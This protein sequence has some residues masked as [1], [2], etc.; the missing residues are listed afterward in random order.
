LP[1]DFNGDLKVDASDIDFFSGKIGQVAT[2]DSVLD[3]DQDGLITLAD[4]D[5]LIE[6]LIP[7]PFG[8]GAKVGDLNFDGSVDTLFDAA[9][10]I[11]NLGSLGG[12]GDGDLNADGIVDVLNDAAILINNQD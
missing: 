11:D 1:G 10:L 3:L 7:V 2:A 5:Y 9:T 4:H 12:Y 8:T 6:S